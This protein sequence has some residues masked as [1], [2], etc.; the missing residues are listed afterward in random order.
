MT[1]IATLLWRKPEW[2]IFGLSYGII[3]YGVL[4]L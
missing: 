2:F 4:F 3:L 1:R